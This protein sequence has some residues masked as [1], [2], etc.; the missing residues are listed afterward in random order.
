[1]QHS[2]IP[3]PRYAVFGYSARPNSSWTDHEAKKE[4]HESSAG[5]SRPGDVKFD[6]SYHPQSSFGLDLRQ[7]WPPPRAE[8]NPVVSAAGLVFLAPG[9]LPQ[10]W[11]QVLGLV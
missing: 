6:I 7:S 1:M 5:D 8:E 10:I 11:N 4:G 3:T 2:K 9:W